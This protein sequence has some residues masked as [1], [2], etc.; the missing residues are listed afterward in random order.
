MRERGVERESG[1]LVVCVCVCVCARVT[2]ALDA[3]VH[4]GRHA[5]R[6]RRWPPRGLSN[7]E[8]HRD[9]QWGACMVAKHLVLTLFFQPTK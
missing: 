3:P 2:A 5:V 9:L 4:R 8:S 1:T 6:E 7:G